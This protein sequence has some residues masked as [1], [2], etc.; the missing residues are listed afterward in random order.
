MTTRIVSEDVEGILSAPLPWES[1]EGSNVLVTGASGMLGAYFIETLMSLNQRLSSTLRVVALV[2][3]KD[4]ASQRFAHLLDNP[5]FEIL[6]HDI[7]QPL[8]TDARFD[9]IIHAAS[10]ASPKVF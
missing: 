4:Y 8:N 1:F 9:Y 10:Q 5:S 7:S 2:R 3:N 6:S